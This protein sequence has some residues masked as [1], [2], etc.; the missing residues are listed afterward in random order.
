MHELSMD[1]RRS[2]V[3]V[4][5]TKVFSYACDPVPL[6][7]YYLFTIQYAMYMCKI[8]WSLCNK[9]KQLQ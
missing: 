9:N 6:N 7:K 2:A 3:S 1:R 8:S 5:Q 4:S